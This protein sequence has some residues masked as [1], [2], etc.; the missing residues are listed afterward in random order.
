MRRI[1][2]VPAAGH[3]EANL[4]ALTQTLGN[5]GGRPARSHRAVDRNAANVR[6]PPPLELL[7]AKLDCV[8]FATNAAPIASIIELRNAG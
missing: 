8:L 4:A 7:A 6:R 2:V 3:I 1:G 5:A